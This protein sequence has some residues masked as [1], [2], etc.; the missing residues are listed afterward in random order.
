MKLIKS[1]PILF[2]GILATMFTACENQDV[3]F[4]DYGTTSVYFAYQYPVRTIV[5]GDD[6]YD[7]TLDNQHKCKIYATMGG[8]YKNSKDI[9][10][11]VKV[12]NS[13]C[14]KLFFPDGSPVKPMPSNY[15]SLASDKISLNKTLSDGVEVQ[16]NDAFFADENALANTYVIPLL[17][18]NV[19]N[20]DK[21]L[22]GTLSVG[23]NNPS[24]SN[25]TAWNVQPQDYVLYCLKY[26][27]PWHAKYLRRGIDQ[28]T[29]NGT[30]TK[31]V[32]HKQYVENDE[33]CGLTTKSLKSTVFPVSTTIRV[34]EGSGATVQTLTCNLILTFN[35]N[36]ECT[37][38]SGTDGYAAS[39]SGKF[40]KKGEKKSWGNK[41]RDALYLDYNIDFNVK[42]FATKDTLVVQSRGVSMEEFNPSYKE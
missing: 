29:E 14:D 10:I 22:S 23:A 27:N 13:L 33:V 31:N 21:I 18:T 6:E 3:E 8:V 32:R 2:T 7:T 19:T 26:I 1:L 30:T 5:L 37:I 12:D 16:L 17:M 40:V 39:G 24:R 38:T 15:Y 4:P 34:G 9:T 28:I 42:K 35:E 36:N 25:T 41:D 20:A 11:D